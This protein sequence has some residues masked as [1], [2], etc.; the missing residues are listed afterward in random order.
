MEGPLST[1]DSVHREFN[2]LRGKL[3]GFIEACGLDEKQ[4]RGLVR[5]MKSLSY[6]AEEAL[7]DLLKD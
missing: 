6:D 4:E 7:V 1:E 5:T 3:A 2:R